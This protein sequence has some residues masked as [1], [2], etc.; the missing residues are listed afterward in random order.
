MSALV[1][2][3]RAFALA[4]LS[5]AMA[6]GAAAAPQPPARV[7]LPADVVPLEYRIDFTPDTARLAFA[8]TVDIDVDIRR[9]T[10]RIVVNSADLEIDRAALSGETRAPE[11][12]FDTKVETA[13][14]TFDHVLPAGRRT[15]SLAYRG[16]IVD[17]MAGLFVRRY[18]TPQGERSALYTQFENSDA[19]RFVPCWD[20][21][22]RK[23]VFRLSA[24]VDPALMA[25]GNMPIAQSVPQP[26]G[27]AH[28]VF[29]PTPRMSSYL[30]FFALGDFE[31]LHRDVAGTEVGIV[32]KRG[33]LAQAGFALDAASQLL[34]FYNDY[35]GVRFPLPKLDLVAAPGSG[36]GFGA[37]EN[38]GAIYYVERALLIDP[39][40]STQ[41]D[42][43]DVYSVIAHEMAHQWFGDLVTMAW[44][45]DIWLNEGFAS[46]MQVKAADHFH[47]E[48]K[49]WLQ[50]LVDKQ[51]VMGVDARDGT[52]PVIRP[53]VDV[54]AASTAFD[55][56]TYSKGQQVIRTIEAV[57]GEERFRDGVRRYM[58]EHAYG[59]TT[60]DDFWRSLGQAGG[61]PV[62]TLAHE[63][64][65]QAGVPLV[66]QRTLACSG[67]RTTMTLAQERFTLG[68]P[69]EGRWHLPV[70]IAM[71]GG[72]STRVV[73][74]GPADQAVALPGCGAVVLNA[75]QKAY[76]RSQYADAGLKATLAAYA[77]LSDEDQL[78]L[79]QDAASL[80]LAG[81]APMAQVFDIAARMPPEVDPVVASALIGQ[82]EEIDRLHDGLPSQAAWREFARRLLAPM[83]A[84]IGPRDRDGD[85]DNLRSERQALLVL[86][87]ALDDPGVVADLRGQFETLRQ[88][89]AP[90]MAPT[91]R[92]A[93]LASVSLHADAATWAQLRALAEA[94]SATM[95]KADL[96]RRLGAAR[97]PA[98]ASRALDLAFSGQMQR[99][100]ALRVLTKVAD[101]HPALALDFA[102]AHWAWIEPG[103]D[104]SGGSGYVPR[105][106]SQSNDAALAAK[107]DAFVAEHVPADA[108]GPA[109]RA[110]AALLYRADL[111]ARRV[112]EVDQLVAAA[113]PPAGR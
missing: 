9:P 87:S 91:L 28:V 18:G 31:R 48:W 20:E 89:S 110:R 4:I 113:G 36:T 40:L 102:A 107:L 95:E 3:W 19:R 17:R 23:A 11:I 83:L 39:R 58:R 106:L 65:L 12:A 13:T 15:L 94:A 78:G 30:L 14:F 68:P 57:V 77:S 93:V 53:V 74:H 79:F 1:L 103:L 25:V 38:W 52:H 99:V 72:P 112:P 96:L 100:D 62:S 108:R 10:R 42:R 22:A 82:I 8:G 21:P 59:N 80:A 41:D 33:D 64:T 76:F 6:G 88:P 98:L 60:S 46:W 101:A 35:F 75:G 69:L 111:R 84:R 47:P 32:V 44:W 86:L 43:R 34:A 49:M 45:D 26:D 50:A 37:M 7:V 73:V 105:L 71:A 63:L 5:L 66:V 51:A 109:Q 61:G 97:D 56:I 92:E 70:A 55:G 81:R 54:Q 27:L 67:G 16:R 29:A 2:R 90:P 24:H 85:G 104:L